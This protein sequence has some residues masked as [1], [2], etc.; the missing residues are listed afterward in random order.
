MG[1]LYQGI[2][3]PFSG[4]V[5]P[6]V[7]YM[8]KSRAC[9]R[10]YRCHVNYPDTADQQQQRNW[11][12]GMVRFAA[13]ATEALKLGLAQQA[14]AARMTE[15][16]LFVLKNKQHFHREDDSVTIDYSKLQIAAG[17]ATDVYF[18]K[19][20]F[21]QNETIVVD[22]EKNSLSLKASADDRVYVYIYATGCAQ[23]LLAAPVSR[24]DKQLRIALPHEWSGQEVHLYGFVVDR[25]GRASNSTYI[26]V[27]R[28]NHYE[29][30][31]RYIPLDN[32][33]Q[34]FVDLA[35]GNVPDTSEDVNITTRKTTP[36][37]AKEP[38]E[39]P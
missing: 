4:K 35:S 8:W 32:N 31:G 38:P 3:G 2:E 34:E 1:K 18:H 6:V 24:R 14:A 36:T 9:I 39:V 37:E 11:F 28:V 12:V 23:G 30:R 13:Q 16:N 17:S 21:E 10:S 7:G 25:D 33:W 22:F 26:G 5:G 20:R 27:G 19:P 29:D 15:G